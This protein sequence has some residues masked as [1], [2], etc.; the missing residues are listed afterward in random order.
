MSSL[1]VL[2]VQELNTKVCLLLSLQRLRMIF[3]FIF[4]LS[5]WRLLS[6]GVFSVENIQVSLLAS[7]FDQSVVQSV[8]IVKQSQIYIASLPKKNFL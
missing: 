5:L 4:E 8:E 3:Y 2:V 1:S 7:F 6:G